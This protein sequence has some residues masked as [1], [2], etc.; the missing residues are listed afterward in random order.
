MFLYHGTNIKFYQVKIIK[1]NR[2]LD[3]GVGFY[4]T[5]DKTQAADWAKV[6]VKRANTGRS[7]L[8]IYEF[9]EKSI[10]KL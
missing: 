2:T 9:D 8:N 7:F 5:S 4:T 1:P 3:F 10:E 6:V